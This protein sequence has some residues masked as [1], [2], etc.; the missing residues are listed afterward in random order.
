MNPEVRLRV[1]G[2]T[3]MSTIDWYGNVSLIVFCAGCNY[4]CPYCHNSAL[5]PPDSGREIDL[6]LLKERIMANKLID[7]AIV[8]TG[9]EPVLQPDAIIEA[10]KLSKSL[11]LK[12]MLDTNGSVKQNLERILRSG[13]IDRVALDVK[14]PLNPTDYGRVT[15]RPD[16]GEASV[17]A[18]EHCLNLSKELGLE[19]EVRT[20]VAPGLSDAPTFIASIAESI[21]GRCDVYYL[22]QYDN[23]GEVLSQTL[24]QEKP[25]SRETM[26]SLAQEAHRTGLTNVFIKTR[27]NGLERMG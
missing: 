19:M 3:D 16:L 1:G 8:F 18:V 27:S 14:A 5:I 10:A 20:T 4:R 6:N 24:K 25:P 13:Y 11:G 23:L 12:V 22:Q 17:E 7:D 2:I 26:M 15:G 21:K 9:G